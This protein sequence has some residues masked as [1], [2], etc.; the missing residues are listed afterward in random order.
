MSEYMITWIRSMIA[1]EEREL[2]IVEQWIG[3]IGSNEIARVFTLDACGDAYGSFAGDRIGSCRD[4]R[5]AKKII[6][7]RWR[8]V[9]RQREQR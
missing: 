8:Q 9:A 7:V 2:G 1:A 4:I 3:F 6:E 5:M